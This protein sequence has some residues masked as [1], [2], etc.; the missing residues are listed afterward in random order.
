MYYRCSFCLH[1]SM[2]HVHAVT[3]V[4]RR[5]HWIPLGTGNTD[6]LLAHKWVL[7]IEPRSSLQ[8]IPYN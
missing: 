7:G 1:V 4:A 5:G 3:V 8:P 6:Q 2:H